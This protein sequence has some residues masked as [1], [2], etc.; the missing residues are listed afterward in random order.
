[1]HDPISKTSANAYANKLSSVGATWTSAPFKTVQ[2]P[3]TSNI[4]NPFF[5][6]IASIIYSTFIKQQFKSDS[7][8][9]FSLELQL[10]KN[11]FF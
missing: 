1:M 4:I 2:T 6:D 3:M 11:I 9:K 5:S 8:N 10:R 7:K